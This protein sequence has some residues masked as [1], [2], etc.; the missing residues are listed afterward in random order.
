[1][2]WLHGKPGCGKSVLASTIISEV[3]AE[4]QPSHVA[5]IA[6]FYFDF[7]DAEK[8]TP[9]QLVRSLLRQLFPMTPDTFAYLEALFLDCSEGKRQMDLDNLLEVL[10]AIMCDA[11]EVYVV[12]N[13]L[14]EC[15]DLHILLSILT[16]CQG[17]NLPQLHALFTSRRLIPIEYA[18]ENIIESRFRI[19]VQSGLVDQDISSY[20][21]NRLLVDPRLRRWRKSPGV[22]EE[23]RSLLTR[24]A[25]GM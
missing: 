12:V 23:I 6:Y 18:S 7:N 5:G 13:A 9:E 1:M 17:W 4:R 19:N 20:V 25:D 22:Q 2:L 10:K 3:L 24:K 11:H 16:K 15:S 21:Q 14:D 8:P